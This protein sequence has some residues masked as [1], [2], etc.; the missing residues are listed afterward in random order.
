MTDARFPER[1]LNDRR[2]LRL[3]DNGFRLFVAG[4]V[5]SVANRT[6]G[7]LDAE[8]LDLMPRVDAG[9]AAELEKAGL[10]RRDRDT[11]VIVEFADTQTSVDEL[12]ALENI[13]RSAR[14]RKARERARKAASRDGHADGHGDLHRTG[15]DRPGQAKNFTEREANPWPPVA[16]VQP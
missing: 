15:Q 5:W 10:W 2:L 11:W 16:E 1:W 3:S 13:R 9:Q 7:V 14:V 6:A 4:L 12:V 8:D